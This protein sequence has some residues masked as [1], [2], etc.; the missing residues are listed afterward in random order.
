VRRQTMDSQ[1]GFTLIELL[2]VIII[3]GILAAIAIPMYLNQ[4]ERAKDATVKEGIHSIQVGVATF[5]TDTPAAAFPDPGLVAED[6]IVG[7][8]V[9]AWP[10]DPWSNTRAPM[11]ND[12][13]RGNFSYYVTAD[14]QSMGMDGFGSHGVGHANA[15]ISVG[16]YFGP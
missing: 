14:R 3:I 10:A 15:L 6:Q 13:T 8:Y 11:V 2:I 7:T 5:V 9:K 12:G 4:R 1:R 16:T